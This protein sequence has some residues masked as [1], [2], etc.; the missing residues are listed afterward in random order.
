MIG[1][2]LGSNTIRFVEIDCKTKKRVKE[3]EK[4]VKTAEGL[5][6]SGFISKEATKRVIEAVL[7]AKKIFDFSKDFVAVT[8]EAVR[9]AKN[10]KEF[11]D[12]VYNKT[13][14]K[15]KILTGEE[16]AFFTNFAVKE[17]VA[18]KSYTLF[19]IGGGSTEISLVGETIFSNSF[20][21]GIVTLTE[22]GLEKKL[23]I[24]LFEIK[25][26]FK[27]KKIPKTCVATAGTP[28]TIAAFLNGMDY[29]SYDYKKINKT[30]LTISD[31][32]EAKKRL[33]G[34]SYQERKRWVGRYR[35]RGSD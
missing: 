9:V 33:L 23:P 10:Q 28:T 34:L 4:I 35:E 12:E 13:G 17:Q 18:T 29:D 27:D 6:K 5:K 1:C 22:E 14:V 31:I 7:E 8:T 21:L 32:E 19:D 11:L 20:S 3:F 30:I 15:F 2:D 26:F 24:K 16:E 25:E